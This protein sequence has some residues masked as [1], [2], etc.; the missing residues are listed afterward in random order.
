MNSLQKL[1]QIAPT[2]AIN[3]CTCM[4]THIKTKIKLWFCSWYS[5][6]R[7]NLYSATRDWINLPGLRTNNRQDPWACNVLLCW[8]TLM[9]TF[10]FWAVDPDGVFFILF[11]LSKPISSLQKNKYQRSTIW[12]LWNGEGFFLSSWLDSCIFIHV[13]CS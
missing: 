12:H 6:F 1:L 4:H 11:Q 7:N 9:L 10:L 8:P 3:Q 13:C 2:V 5:L